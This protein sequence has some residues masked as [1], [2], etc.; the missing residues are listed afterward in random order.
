MKESASPR[1]HNIIVVVS[2]L[3][4][5]LLLLLTLAP[6]ARAQ[7]WYAHYERAEQAIAAEDWDA[8]VAAIA[9]ALAQRADSGNR[10]RTPGGRA[11]T[12][13]PYLKLGIAYC[14]LNRPEAAL[15]AFATEEQLG[16]IAGSEP[17][18][19]DLARFREVA[20]DLL[21]T[22][23]A[24]EATRVDDIV[25]ANLRSAAELEAAGELDEAITALGRALAVD[26]D[27]TA[28]RAAMERLQSGMAE[29]ATTARL[30]HRVTGLV[31]LGRT[32]LEDG[33]PL[34]AARSLRQA[35]SLQ[36]SDELQ[37]LLDTAQARVRAEFA[38][39]GGRER[40]RV[41]G[42]R[43]PRGGGRFSDLGALRRI[44]D[45][46]D[47][48]QLA[49][50]LEA[51]QRLLAA[52]PENGRARELQIR[53]LERQSEQ[54]RATVRRQ[55]VDA[56]LVE[57]AAA[58]EADDVDM[59]LTRATRVLALEPTNE[60]A[61]EY[62]RLS[63]SVMKARLMGSSPMENIPPAIRFADFR[64]DLEDGRQAQV[65]QSPEFRLSGVIIDTTPVEVTVYDGEAREIPANVTSQS[66]GDYYL[67]EFMLLHEL[68]ADTT[69]F[70]LVANDQALLSSS[71][72][73]VVVYRSPFVG[74]VAF[75][76]LLAL[77]LVTGGGVAYGRRARQ[78]R[79]LLT[80]RFNPYVAGAPVLDEKMFF[81]REA[82]LDRV[83]QTVHSN[84]LLLYGE[85]RIGKTSLQHQLKRRLEALDDPTYV[86]YP[87]FID[88]Q[89]TPEERFF[90]TLAE[91]VFHTLEPHLDGLQPSGDFS[92]PVDYTYRQF[93]HDMR[94][95]VRTLTRQNT[96]TV[97]VV[98][99]IDEVD[100]LNAYDPKVNQRLRSFFMKT[101]AE[102]LAAVVSGVQIQKQW[103]LEGS[104]WYNF[105]EEIEVTPF[106]QEYAAELIT[107]PLR[108]MFTLDTGVVER[109]V[110]LTGGRP[111]LIQKLCIAL[112][113]RMHE[114]NRRTIGL[115]DVGAVDPLDAA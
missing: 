88:L 49:Q 57:T 113:N 22:R 7:P 6:A 31:E 58:F 81:G 82:L 43:P 10:V 68:S 70:R 13:F 84:S 85:R 16:A 54:E 52:A 72:E 75:Y 19:A 73:Y 62:V 23:R 35:H 96:K 11:T 65:V 55:T 77:G 87:V 99:Q 93:V 71:S 108:G 90:A 12:Y 14:N 80:R 94:Q 79:R 103:E 115:D 20:V 8:A 59:A 15:Q 53:I 25:A 114:T 1:G 37:T 110:E 64:E 51:L 102:N 36:P 112:V 86:F 48:G 61:H 105:F 69:T 56:L 33:R 101:F 66:L 3:P 98:L 89:G 50:A 39:P 97:K 63:Y 100:E 44:E 17:A 95:V 28:A 38:D 5:V 32:L 106:N 2:R 74:S 83:L 45:L 42:R 60:T 111:Y 76:S 29:T 107:R 4:I 24:E 67:T 40:S 47:Q 34:Q 18:L 9:Q 92:R 27:N 104:P 91:E 41:P 46:E 78:R 21:E 109:I 26:A 30:R